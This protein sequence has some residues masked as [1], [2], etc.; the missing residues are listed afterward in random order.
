MEAGAGKPLREILGEAFYGPWADL[1]RGDLV[2]WLPAAS[3][4]YGEGERGGYEVADLGRLARR[5]GP[6]RLELPPGTVNRWQYGRARGVSQKGGRR[7]P[8]Q[9][10]PPAVV[11][12]SGG[13][14][15]TTVLAIAKDEGFAPYALSFSYGQ[16][17]SVELGAARR[18]ASHLGAAEHVV[19]EFDLRAFGGSALT[20]EIAVPHHQSAAGIGE[21]I[22]VTYVPARNTIFLSFAL[23]WAETLSSHD[24]FI[25][26]NAVDYSGYPDCR[27][28]FITAFEDLATLAT[29]VGVEGG[30]RLAVHAPLSHMSKAQIIQRGLALGVDYGLTHSCYDPG[31][32]GHPCG[33]CDSCLLRAKGFEEVGRPDP[34]LS[35]G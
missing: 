27:P 19:V 21:G 5:R 18:V 35:V 9:S 31:P 4:V 22:P 34:A 20:S 6:G 2:G 30:P 24:I 12:L 11:L 10:K 3:L 15:S 26:V 32:D 13:L 17:H 28:E 8:D 23:A 7:V 14:D 29:K 25:G 16:R 1:A 33:T